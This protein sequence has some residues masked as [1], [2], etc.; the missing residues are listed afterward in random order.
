MNGRAAVVV[1][2]FAGILSTSHLAQA[3]MVMQPTPRPIVTAE[4]EPWFNAAAPIMHAC[5]WYYPTGPLTGFNG[6][7]MVRSGHFQGIPLYSR[8]FIEPFS[9]IFVPLAGGWMQPYERRRAGE[10]AD[11]AGSSMPSFP[12]VRPAE[13]AGMEFL[14]QA[15][16][17]PSQLEDAGDR[18]ALAEVGAAGATPPVGTTGIEPPAIVGPLTTARRP[19]GLNGVYIEFRDR[20]YFADGPAVAFDE[21]V[22]TRI[23]DYHGYPV[24][25]HRGQDTTVYIPSLAGEQGV[26]A[27]YRVR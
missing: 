19:E 7:E 16:A 9:V 2:A 11:T 15:P 12:V 27:P 5:N 4:S 8:K 3:Q 18:I 21:R 20:R 13:Q 23:G 24:F 1:G 22:F 6:H 26:L 17:P 14:V 10:L 25:K